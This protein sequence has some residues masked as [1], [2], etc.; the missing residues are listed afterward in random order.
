MSDEHGDGFAHAHKARV[1]GVNM[2]HRALVH[3][4]VGKE[5]SAV[6]EVHV[7]VARRARLQIRAHHHVAA[8]QGVLGVGVGK[9]IGTGNHDEGHRGVLF[10]DG[11]VNAVVRF[12]QVFG[13]GR[14]VI[15]IAD[16]HAHGQIGHVFIE[17]LLALGVAG[18]A[19]VD[20]IHIQQ[21]ADVIFV[22]V[23]R[24]AGGGAMY[25]GG[26]VEDDLLKIAVLFARQQLRFGGKAHFQRFHYGMHGE[27]DGIGMHAGALLHLDDLLIAV[28]HVVRHA[29]FL[30]IAA[31]EIIVDIQ[32][33]ACR[34]Y[35][36]QM[37][38]AAHH[39]EFG[40]D[41]D[42]GRICGEAHAAARAFLAELF[43]GRA[44][45]GGHIH[46]QAVEKA[47]GGGV[48][49]AVNVKGRLAHIMPGNGHIADGGIDDHVFIEI[50]EIFHDKR[51]LDFF[52]LLYNAAE[53]FARKKQCFCNVQKK[54]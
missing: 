35:Q 28:R 47:F 1:V 26:A 11:L 22:D 19:E 51:S 34:G 54:L 48:V 12:F 13:A 18:K 31:A 36:R 50:D 8:L 3:L 41:G 15:V 6:D 37:R 5:G 49:Q 29:E 9:I 33:K 30:H 24:T 38:G 23:A 43:N 46:G 21:A 14:V 20:V 25:N 2:I 44:G 40:A 32:V 53:N 16:K 7:L 39:A 17:R 45:G 10:A 42:E 4:R 27:I 52:C